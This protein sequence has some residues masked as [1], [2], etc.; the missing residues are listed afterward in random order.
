MHAIGGVCVLAA[1][2]VAPLHFVQRSDGAWRGVFEEDSSERSHV[3]PH[4]DVIYVSARDYGYSQQDFARVA[5][6]LAEVVPKDWSPHKIWHHAIYRKPKGASDTY[7]ERAL[8]KY[9]ALVDQL[10]LARRK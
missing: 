9:N 1:V 6:G 2:P 3:L 7:F 5:R 4:Y 10:R 8:A